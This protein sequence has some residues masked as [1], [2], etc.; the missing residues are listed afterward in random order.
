MAEHVGFNVVRTPAGV[1]KN[2]LRMLIEMLED[3]HHSQ[4]GAHP[5]L[6]LT[7]QAY[8][9]LGRDQQGNLMWDDAQLDRYITGKNADGTPAQLP[10]TVIPLEQRMREKGY[11]FFMLRNDEGKTVAVASGNIQPDGTL[12]LMNITV[13]RPYRDHRDMP[14]GQKKRY[15]QQ[16]LSNVAAEMAKP[17]YKVNNIVIPLSAHAATPLGLARYGRALNALTLGAP[18]A[19]NGAVAQEQAVLTLNDQAKVN[20]KA[21]GFLDT[22][23]PPLRPHPA[24]PQSMEIV[25]AP[26]TMEQQK[27]DQLV[28]QS[29]VQNIVRTMN[30]WVGRA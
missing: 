7:I 23:F 25:V 22:D 28:A 20:W 2:E 24:D 14:E 3:L 5:R 1:T 17:E 29:W 8:G 13:D 18:T 12:R 26:K 27:H 15:F 21:A 30:Q 10:P 19:A 6:G 16:L 9:Y 11:T 4:R